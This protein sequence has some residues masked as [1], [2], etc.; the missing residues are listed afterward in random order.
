MT[1]R[2]EKN[3]KIFGAGILVFGCVTEVNSRLPACH[4]LHAE[5]NEKGHL[6]ILFLHDCEMRGARMGEWDLEHLDLAKLEHDLA[7]IHAVVLTASHIQQDGFEAP[8][9]GGKITW[10]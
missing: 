8:D 5:F 6:A 9:N 1:K 7:K 2:Q 3:Q 4:R 10:H